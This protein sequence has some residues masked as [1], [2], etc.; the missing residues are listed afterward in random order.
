[1]RRAL[2]ALGVADAD[3]VPISAP[4]TSPQADATSAAW[5]ARL[6]EELERRG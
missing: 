4:A 5:I 3:A 2:A 1:L 6:R